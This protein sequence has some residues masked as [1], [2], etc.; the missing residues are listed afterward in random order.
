MKR[1]KLPEIQLIGRVKADPDKLML[2][3]Q[4]D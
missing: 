2:D 4:L 3:L 1:A